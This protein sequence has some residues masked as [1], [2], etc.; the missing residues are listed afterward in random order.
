MIKKYMDWEGNIKTCW[1]CVAAQ[2]YKF[3]CKRRHINERDTKK[4]GQKPNSRQL[5][6]QSYQEQMD[7]KLVATEK[8]R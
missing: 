7:S 1:L 6:D 5:Y 3:K 2:K 8:D 4:P